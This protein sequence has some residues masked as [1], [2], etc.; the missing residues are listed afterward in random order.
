MKLNYILKVQIRDYMVDTLVGRYHQTFTDIIDKLVEENVNLLNKGAIGFRYNGSVYIHSNVKNQF[1]TAQALLDLRKHPKVFNL[2][3]DLTDTMS[4]SF[5]LE[6]NKKMEEARCKSFIDF[7]LSLC[8]CTTEVLHVFEYVGLKQ[9]IFEFQE[10]TSNNL[11]DVKDAYI[12]IS[13]N[14]ELKL[15]TRMAAFQQFLDKLMVLRNILGI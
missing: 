10:E 15:K 8:E 11:H 4:E 5:K 1:K 7:C 2:H 13:P 9:E 12:S 14:K 6:L 3:P